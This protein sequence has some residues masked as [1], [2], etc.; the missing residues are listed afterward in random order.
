[1]KESETESVCVFPCERESGEGKTR[2]IQR[3]HQDTHEIPQVWV[4]PGTFEGPS[5]EFQQK[6]DM[7]LLILVRNVTLAPMGLPSRRTSS[8]E[9]QALRWP[10]QLD[11]RARS[12]RFA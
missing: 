5:F 7:K 1:M 4:A 12:C 8:L 6:L 9:A 10:L 2:V 11:G 3:Q